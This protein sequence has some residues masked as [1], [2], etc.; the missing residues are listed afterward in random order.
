VRLIRG[1]VLRVASQGALAARLAAGPTSLSGWRLTGL[2]L[3]PYAEQ[4]GQVDVAGAL[5]VDCTADGL[6]DDLRRRGALVFDAAPAMPVDTGRTSLYTPD[7]L[8]DT[9]SYD[10]SL[11]ARVYGWSKQPPTRDLRLAE[12]LHDFA[13]DEALAEWTGDRRIAGVMGGHALRR[14]ERG[15]RYAARL[16]QGLGDRFTVATGGGPGAMEA[17]NLGAWL[18]SP[19][20]VDAAMS[21]LAEVPSFRPDIGAWAAAGFA[22]L[23]RWPDG[24]DS[25]GIPTWHY[26][27]EPPNVFASAVAKYFRNATR[28]AILLQLCDAGIVFLEGA[29]GTVQEIF[30]DACENYYADESAIAPMVLVGRAYWTTEVPAWPLL[31]RLARGRAMEGHVHLV[32][33][34][35]EALAVI[36]A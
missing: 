21:L 35:D 8:Y 28:E 13:I 14:G 27:H 17:A 26:G 19:E 36:G 29:G 25:L 22:V 5:F 10:T 4:L 18:D 7:E 31:R 6:A 34:V 23:D 33:T 2:D 30:Q 3:R 16:G 12:A 1:R 20:D 9:P 11:D 15:Y 24:R 32:D